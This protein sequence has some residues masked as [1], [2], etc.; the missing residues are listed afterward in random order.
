MA[1]T[2]APEVKRTPLKRGKPWRPKRKPIARRSK[3]KV[4]VDED[5]S[6][7]FRAWI[8][9]HP[10]CLCGARPVDA[11]HIRNIG[12]G[13]T[14]RLYERDRENVVPHCR[15]CHGYYESHKAEYPAMKAVAIRLWAQWEESNR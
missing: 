9:S 8:R 12:M 2:G 11:S 4:R 15:L 13:G 10:C 1:R 6:K 5:L 14:T 7:A 3:T